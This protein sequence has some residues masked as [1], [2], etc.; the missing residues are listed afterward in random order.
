MTINNV[1][2]LKVFLNEHKYSV[3]KYQRA[4][5]WKKEVDDLWYDL[6]SLVE[7]KNTGDDHFFGQIVIHDNKDDRR[8]D[9]VDGQ[10]RTCTAVILLS[11]MRK[12]L[13]QLRENQTI[14]NDVVYLIGI[15]NNE[16]IGYKNDQT[17]TLKFSLGS[18]ADNN[19]FKDYIQ[20]GTLEPYH[21]ASSEYVKKLNSAQKNIS[22][23]YWLFD[24]K[25]LELFEGKNDEAKYDIVKIYMLTFIERFKVMYLETNDLAEAYDIFESLN[26]RGRELDT[27]DLLKNHLFKISDNKL[28]T[29]M[30]NW[31]KMI[32]ELGDAKPTTFI[33]YYWNSQHSF[34]T[35]RELYR[36]IRTEI[37]S[38]QLCEKLV[39]ELYAASSVYSA[40]SSPKN[41][42]GCFTSKKIIASVTGLKDMKATLYYPIVLS[43]MHEKYSEHDIEK[44]LQ[45]I[46]LL[47]FRNVVVSGHGTNKFERDFANI[48]VTISKKKNDKNLLDNIISQLKI[49]IVSDDKFK[50]A[51]IDYTGSSTSK[52]AIRYML[53][54]INKDHFSDAECSS[55]NTELP[56]EHI[57]PIK[58]KTPQWDVSPSIHE[59]YLWRLGNLTLMGK[60]FNEKASAKSFTDKKIEYGK[61]NMWTTNM[62]LK[63]DKWTEKEIDDRQKIL[64]QEIMRLWK[65]P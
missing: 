40:L 59:T 23:A 20:A 30:T 58:I 47:V 57:M 56:I 8:Y 53:R 4:Y 37:N 5:T 36:K 34:T 39:N 25:L 60:S 24:N 18:Y 55:D 9:L 54:R 12:Y 1:R 13:H 49:Q 62:L 35:E 19:Y 26:A 46:E 38:E 33:R 44:I 51:L 10:Q 11:V 48:A 61:S 3:P 65:V 21:K 27:A 22:D 43:L 63:Y 16:V 6:V 42:D 14:A 45:I 7:S 64:A 32:S 31:D 2:T 17:D 15:L 52:N 50:P 29:V 41:A 28:E